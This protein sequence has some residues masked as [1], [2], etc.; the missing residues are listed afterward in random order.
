[1]H[2]LSATEH[3][4][5]TCM[6]LVPVTASLLAFWT[7]PLPKGRD[8]QRDSRRNWDSPPHTPHTCRGDHPTQTP[9]PPILSLPRTAWWLTAVLG[10]ACGKDMRQ[11]TQQGALA[12]SK[13]QC[14]TFR[15]LSVPE[16]PGSL[17]CTAWAR[18]NIPSP[19]QQMPHSPILRT[20]L[21]PHPHTI[22]YL[23]QSCKSSSSTT[24]PPTSPSPHQL[25]SRLLTLHQPIRV[26]VP[27]SSPS[28]PLLLHP[29]LFQFCSTV[30]LTKGQLAV[31]ERF[32]GPSPSL[33]PAQMSGA[34]RT[35]D[36]SNLCA[37]QGVGVGGGGVVNC[38]MS[39]KIQ[40]AIVGKQLF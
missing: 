33:Y 16:A 15:C 27:P 34:F 11:G 4:D 9:P 1:M 8:E 20:A 7:T 35:R 24:P 31:F 36:G 32:V 12:R 38:G 25:P 39:Q 13:R 6:Y 19:R 22:H 28:T 18:P 3:S 30:R 37:T 40:W 14:A 2:F 17:E 10:S 23:P 5:L 29:R 26:V 21:P